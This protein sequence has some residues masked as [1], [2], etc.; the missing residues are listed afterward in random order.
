M[1]QALRA[2]TPKSPRTRWFVHRWSHRRAPR[3][4]ASE[5]NLEERRRFQRRRPRRQRLVTGP[6]YRGV[7]DLRSPSSPPSRASRW[8]AAGIRS[9]ATWSCRR[10]A[11]LGLPEVS[12]GSSP[13][14]AAPAVGPTDR[15]RRAAD[16]GLRGPAGSTPTRP[17][18]LGVVDRSAGRAGNGSGRGISLAARIAANSPVDLRTARSGDAARPGRG[19]WPRPRDQDAAWRTTAFERRTE[20]RASQPSPR[21]RAALARSLTLP[22]PGRALQGRNRRRTIR[23]PWPV[24]H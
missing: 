4:S 23:P 2:A 14:V 17:I 20:R 18:R 5:Q 11:V 12:V 8:V 9:A 7:L 24:S 6:A 22:L 13:V 19:R 3:H 10:T 1:A 15:C 16:P 21:H